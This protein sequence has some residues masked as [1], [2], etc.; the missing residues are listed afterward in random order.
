MGMSFGLSLEHMGMLVGL[1][2]SAQ[3]LQKTR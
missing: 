3:V 1:V 2:I